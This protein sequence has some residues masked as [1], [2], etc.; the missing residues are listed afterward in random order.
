MKTYIQ[1]L[2]EIGKDEVA[3]VSGS[4]GKAEGRVCVVRSP[5]EFSKLQKGDVLV[6]PY[7]DPEWT[8]LFALAAAV[9]SDTGGVL[10]HAAIVAREYRIPAVLAVGNATTALVD[11]DW[12]LV[13][14][15][16]GEVDK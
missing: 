1:K 6:C 9:V 14:G 16:K 10:S 15:S 7:T 8:P 11:G 5:E 12:V 13:D 3:V 2:E 4:A